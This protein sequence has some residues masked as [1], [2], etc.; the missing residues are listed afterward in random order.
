[1]RKI[2]EQ[3]EKWP[4]DEIRVECAIDP[5][6]PTP[7]LRELARERGGPHWVRIKGG[8][9]SNP[10]TPP[11]LV[12][13]LANDE[14]KFVRELAIGENLSTRKLTCMAGDPEDSVRRAARWE[15]KKRKRQT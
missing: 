1:M 11:D 8:V 6:T 12:L 2:K 7:V 5:V 10:S 9:A 3:E 14:H 13:K 15:L 4:N